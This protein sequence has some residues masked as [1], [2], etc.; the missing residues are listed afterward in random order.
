MS[1]DCFHCYQKNCNVRCIDCANVY[2]HGF[3]V[4]NKLCQMKFER[5]EKKLPGKC[6]VC[7]K[8]RRLERMNKMIDKFDHHSGIDRGNLYHL[9]IRDY[10]KQGLSAAKITKRL[11]YLDIDNMLMY[12]I[13][14]KEDTITYLFE[15]EYK[16]ESWDLNNIIHVKIS[17][18]YAINHIGV[19]DKYNFLGKFHKAIPSVKIKGMTQIELDELEE[20]EHFKEEYCKCGEAWED[21]T[22]RKTSPALLVDSVI[23]SDHYIEGHKL[24]I[25]D[26]FNI[27]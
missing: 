22:F 15:G 20:Q 2:Y 6:D 26:R 17:F 9:I 1:F 24:F 19:N 16:Y 7:L 11:K 4:E 5:N 21:H 8:R 14:E 13:D 3:Y 23:P 18:D 25:R 12:T 27:N 10:T